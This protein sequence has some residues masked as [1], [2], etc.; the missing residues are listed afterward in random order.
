MGEEL[1]LV[2]FRVS[3]PTGES[4]PRQHAVTEMLWEGRGSNG[5]SLLLI[6]SSF[7]AR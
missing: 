4:S 5:G 3:T 7:S 2:G 6:E 1:V